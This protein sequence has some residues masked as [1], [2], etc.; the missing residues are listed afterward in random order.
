MRQTRGDVLVRER[1]GDAPIRTRARGVPGAQTPA[2]GVAL[3]HLAHGFLDLAL[4]VRLEALAA[5]VVRRGARDA[6]RRGRVA[7]A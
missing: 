1:F 7:E 3:L 2:L 4:D 5:R 6:L